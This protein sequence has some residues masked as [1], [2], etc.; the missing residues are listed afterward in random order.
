MHKTSYTNEY[1]EMRSR[2]LAENRIRVLRFDNEIVYNN[3]ERIIE[4]IKGACSDQP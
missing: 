3:V 2:F 1:D 4:E